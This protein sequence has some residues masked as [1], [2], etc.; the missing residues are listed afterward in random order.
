MALTGWMSSI[1]FLGQTLAFVALRDSIGVTQVKVEIT[2]GD[3]VGEQVLELLRSTPQER[4][5]HIA[6]TVARR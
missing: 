3:P 6:G 5:L 2:P 1:R 4:I